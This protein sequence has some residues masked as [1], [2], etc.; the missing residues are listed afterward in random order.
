MEK[1][2]VAPGAEAKPIGTRFVIGR[3][4]PVLGGKTG[5][6]HCPG[7]A[8]SSD[9]RTLTRAAQQCYVGMGG[10]VFEGAGHAGLISS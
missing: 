5:R 10:P 1:A 4:L 9:A 8:S 2:N 3:P 7:P 6:R